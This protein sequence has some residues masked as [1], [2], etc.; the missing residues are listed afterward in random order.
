MRRND[1]MKRM[2]GDQH[3]D[4]RGLKS[5]LDSLDPFV[6]A[7]DHMVCDQCDEFISLDEHGVNCDHACL[8]PR[9][10]QD[11]YATLMGRLLLPGC[12][13]ARVRRENTNDDIS[14]VIRVFRYSRSSRPR[15]QRCDDR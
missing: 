1:G 11:A 6:A 5:L 12:A 10:I 7:P 2:F 9:L 15:R 3:I 13:P 8:D 14:P 4:N